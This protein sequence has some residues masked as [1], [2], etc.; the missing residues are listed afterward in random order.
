MRAYP[1]VARAWGLTEAR[2]AQWLGIAPSTY[3]YW[4][5]RPERADLNVDHLE[6]LSLILGI[7]KT[8]HTLLPSEDAADK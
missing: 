3:R 7:Y 1:N 6:R 4:R 2:A 8:S 5:D